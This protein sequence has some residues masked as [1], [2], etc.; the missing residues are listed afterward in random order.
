MTRRGFY[1]LS[2]RSVLKGALASAAI[3]AAVR[4]SVAAEARKVTTVNGV[5]TA[6]DVAKAEAEG[7]CF[8]TRMTAT[9]RALRLSQRSKRISRKSKRRIFVRKM[10]PSIPSFSLSVELAGSTSTSFNTPK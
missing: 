1:E 5:E 4:I 10:A 2:R 9:L 3:P 6:A 8:S 7:A